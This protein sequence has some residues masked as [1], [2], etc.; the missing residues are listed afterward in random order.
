VLRQQ[1]KNPMAARSG[2]EDALGLRLDPRP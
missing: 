2:E 1:R